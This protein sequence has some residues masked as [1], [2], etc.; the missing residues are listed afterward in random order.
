MRWLVARLAAL[1]M[2]RRRLHGSKCP[3]RRG[4]RAIVVA[5]FPLHR[6]R[7]LLR[8]RGYIRIDIQPL[9]VFGG[10]V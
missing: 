6:G 1:S 5:E 10:G 3:W 9:L 2:R 7:E 4:F 8:R